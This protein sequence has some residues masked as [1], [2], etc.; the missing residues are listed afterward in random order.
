M[1]FNALSLSWANSFGLKREIGESGEQPLAFSLQ[2]PGKEC[3][4][5][6]YEISMS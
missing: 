6:L 1:G 3:G 5:N 4:T 2:R